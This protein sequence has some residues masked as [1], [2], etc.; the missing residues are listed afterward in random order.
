[1]ILSKSKIQSVN[2]IQLISDYVLQDKLD[3]LLIIV[4]TNRKIRYLKRELIS[5]S[6]KKSITKLFLYT[7]GTFATK[8]FQSDNY[9]SANVLSDAAAAVLLNKAFNETELK[10]FSNYQGGIPRGTLDRIKNVI[11]EY[12]RNGILP[13]R[14]ILESRQLTGSEELKA[15][16]IANIYQNYLLNCKNLNVYEIGD[17]YSSILKLREEE[18]LHRFI[19]QFDGIKKII[20]NGFDEFTQPE[21]DIINYASNINGVELFVVF[22]YYRFNPALFSHLDLCYENLKAKGFNEIEDTSPVV[23]NNYQKNIREKIFLLDDKDLPKASEINI[24]EISASSPE[25][26]IRLIAKE[27]KHLIYND[28]IHPDSI[29]VSF[30]LIS[31]HSAIVRDIFDEYGIPFNLTDRFALSESQPIIAL[32]NFLEI[33]QNNFYYKNIFRALTGRWIKINGVELSNLLRVSSNLKIVSGYRNWIDS[34]DRVIEETK[35][36]EPDNDNKYLPAHFYSSAKEDII[37]I[38]E[39]LKPFN[40]K[41]KIDEFIDSL[42]HLIFSLRLPEI[43]LND[44]AILIEKNVKA[45]TV[46]LETIDEIFNLAKKENGADKKYSLDYY[47]TQI[48]TALQFT[49]YNIKERHGNGVLVTSVN[50]IRGLN[51]DYVFIGG[52]VDGEFPTRYQPEIFFSGSFKKDDYKHILEERYHFYQALC[53]V[54]KI[55]Y[56]TYAVKDDKKEFTPSTFLTDFSR[57]FLM[58]KKSVENFSELIQSK[59]ELLKMLSDFPVDEVIDKYSKYGIDASKIKSD[60]MIDELRQKDAFAESPYTGSIFNEL[61]EEAKKNL[62]EQKERQYSAS[63]L[64][65][66][67]KCPFQY[68][69]KRILQLEAVEEPTEELESFELGSIVHSILYEFYQTINQE[70]VV[71][72]NCDDETFRQAEKLIFEIAENKIEKLRLYS[73]FLFL[74]RERILGIAGNRK[75]SILYKFLEEERKL[76]EGFKPKYFELEFGKFNN[77]DNDNYNQITIEDINVRGKIDRIDLDETRD[78]FKV[79]DYKLGGKKPSKKDIETGISLQL[80][81]YVYASKILIEA[82]LNKNYKPAAAII[83]SLKMNKNEF[84]EKLVHLSNSRN[85]DEEELLKVNEDLINICNE[86]IPAYVKNITEGKFNLSLLEDRE[87]KVC[88]FCDFKSICRIQEAK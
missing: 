25:E 15:R 64:E 82:E 30:N 21:I 78:Y 5:S 72:S 81:L 56:L 17:I 28:K 3:E 37:K 40:T 4:P 34:I 87:S 12:K 19:N 36:D 74:E 7:L 57:I 69:V 79:I 22:D 8:I 76:K 67:A 33:L 63:Q 11:S 73:S 53:S 10:Y 58:N 70:S 6:P 42:R 60:F 32:I 2:L 62:A 52:L 75:N 51:F 1:M 20:I 9:S 23:F 44:Q 84:G 80:P 38:N 88:R 55:L 29:C 45:L 48:K 61:S 59:A 16:D 27:I 14:I 71:L 65:E 77:S 46:F 85:P 86:F 18:F 47:L 68:F 24:I 31:D 83:Y 49:R 39:L 43:I 66:Y 35:F 54:K 13:E 26:E 41:L 50:E